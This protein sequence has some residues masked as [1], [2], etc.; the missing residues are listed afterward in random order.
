MD[1]LSLTSGSNFLTR[2]E[3]PWHP[4]GDHRWCT[5]FTGCQA[6]VG[7]RHHFKTWTSMDHRWP[8]MEMKI[9]KTASAIENPIFPDLQMGVTALRFNVFPCMD[10][11]IIEFN[12]FQQRRNYDFEKHN[13]SSH[14]WIVEKAFTSYDY[15]N[16]FHIKRTNFFGIDI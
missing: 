13:F 1:S 16:A 10:H 12:T 9:S 6:I 15:R 5:A 11:T 4:T 14:L 3:T 2:T 8:S 7:P